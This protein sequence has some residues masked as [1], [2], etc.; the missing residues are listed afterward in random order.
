MPDGAAAR[1]K[2]FISHSVQR[3]SWKCHLRRI[4]VLGLARVMT[5]DADHLGQHVLKID[6]VI[7]RFITMCSRTFFPSGALIPLHRSILVI[8]ISRLR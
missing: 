2:L 8:N 6:D 5:P 4:C 3:K 7:R 1:S